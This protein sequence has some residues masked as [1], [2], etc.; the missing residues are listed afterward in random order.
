M[1]TI[2]VIKTSTAIHLIMLL[3]ADRYLVEGSSMPACVVTF[4][5]ADNKYFYSSG[6]PLR[7]FLF[8]IEISTICLQSR[9]KENSMGFNSVGVLEFGKEIVFLQI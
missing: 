3:H 1:L 5:L 7:I 9:E 8:N 6:T 4:C 2:E